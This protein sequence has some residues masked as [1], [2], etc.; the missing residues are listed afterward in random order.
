MAIPRDPLESSAIL[1]AGYHP[2]SRTLAIEFRGGRVYHLSGVQPDK[3][4]EFLASGSHGSYYALNLR[5]QHPHE[6]QA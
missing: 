3:A 5:Q 4:A 2:E 1:S 6:K